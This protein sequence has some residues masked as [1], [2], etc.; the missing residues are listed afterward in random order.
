M[1][2]LPEEEV[3]IRDDQDPRVSNATV[4]RKGVIYLI[5]SFR[6]ASCIRTLE[7]AGERSQPQTDR[8]ERRCV[9]LCHWE[10]VT[11]LQP[12]L[13]QYHQDLISLSLLCFPPCWAFLRQAP[14]LTLCFLW[15]KP[16]QR[17]ESIS[18]PGPRIDTHWPGLS[19]VI[20]PDSV[21]S[22]E[23]NR[24]FW[25][26]MRNMSN[27]DLALGEGGEIS[28]VWVVEEVPQIKIRDFLVKEEEMDSGQAQT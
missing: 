28:R 6:R 7:A 19:H 15:T 13:E 5:F 25:L 17:K 23:R 10:V 12:Q 26:G 16:P 22:I 21:T 9:G 27:L 3:I 1:Q 4:L 2:P 20:I 14:C 18:V 8:F 24:R 11:W